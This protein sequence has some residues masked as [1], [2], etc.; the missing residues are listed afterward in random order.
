[1]WHSRT[2]LAWHD[3]DHNYETICEIII[4]WMKRKYTQKKSLYDGIRC[5]KAQLKNWKRG[6]CGRFALF[7]SSITSLQETWFEMVLPTKKKTLRYEW[8]FMALAKPPSSFQIH[9]QFKVGPLVWDYDP[10]ADAM[11]TYTDIHTYAPECQRLTIQDGRNRIVFFFRVSISNSENCQ[12]HTFYD[13]FFCVHPHCARDPYAHELLAAFNP[14][15][16]RTL[17]WA[18]TNWNKIIIIFYKHTDT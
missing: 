4:I 6:K 9:S 5:K 12:L 18:K 13:F 3:Q 16:A 11:A 2:N 14:A 8:R 10:L 1:M 7:S 17:I 15:H